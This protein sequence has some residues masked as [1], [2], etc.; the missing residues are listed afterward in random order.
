MSEKK[1]PAERVVGQREMMTSQMI[2][3]QD[4]DASML[5]HCGL[6]LIGGVKLPDGSVKAVY[7]SEI[8]KGLGLSVEDQSKLDQVLYLQRAFLDC[9]AAYLAALHRVAGPGVELTQEL[10]PKERYEME[11]SIGAEFLSLVRKCAIIEKDLPTIVA[12]HLH[13]GDN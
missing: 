6:A 13:T 5:A 7:D 10:T 12:Q 8:L 4:S 11:Q 9:D 2:A 3:E 1:S